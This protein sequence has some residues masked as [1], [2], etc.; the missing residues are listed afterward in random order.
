MAGKIPAATNG[1]PAFDH[2]LSGVNAGFL[3][4]QTAP[5]C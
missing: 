1:S 3:F 5:S 2:I 4:G